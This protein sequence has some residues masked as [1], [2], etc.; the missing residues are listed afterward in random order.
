MAATETE[1]P[2]EENPLALPARLPYQTSHQP[3]WTKLLSPVQTGVELFPSHK[4][5]RK[6]RAIARRIR[7]GV[8]A[9]AL[10][11]VI[12]SGEMLWLQIAGALLVIGVLFLPI[13]E[14]R[15]RSWVG[16]LRSLRKGTTRTITRPG[17]IVYDGRRVLLEKEGSKLRRV[18]TDRESHVLTLQQDEERLYLKIEPPSDA[19]SD[20]IWVGTDALDP[21][22]LDDAGAVESIDSETPNRPAL[23]ERD[24]WLTLWHALRAS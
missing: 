9:V 1:T 18:L 19:A 10:G 12:F 4:N 8:G 7:I 3:F 6:G 14:V 2:T 24:D 11:I 23:V 17:R 21:S 20:A 5:T 15:K 16:Q 22:E 13:S